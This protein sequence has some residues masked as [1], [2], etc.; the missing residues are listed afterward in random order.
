MNN[1]KFWKAVRKRSIVVNAVRVAIVVGL[2]L[3]LI[4]QS[5]RLRSGMDIAWG[6]VVLNFL[7]PYCVASYSAAK[8]ETNLLKKEERPVGE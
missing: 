8:N 2:I 7:V 1:R 3:N 5:G 6:Q 4:N